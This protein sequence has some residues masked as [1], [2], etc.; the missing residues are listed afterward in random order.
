MGAVARDWFRV[1]AIVTVCLLLGIGYA[2]TRPV[3][4]LATASVLLTHREPR[5]RT[6]TPTRRSGS[7]PT[8]RRS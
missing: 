1:A 8:R 7:W 3:Q 6:A 4:Y 5:P 2:L